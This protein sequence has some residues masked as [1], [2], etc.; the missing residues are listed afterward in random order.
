MDPS[1]LASLPEETRKVVEETFAQALLKHQ[2]DAG[3]TVREKQAQRDE[4]R[5][6]AGGGQPRS[7]AVP[8]PDQCS[9]GYARAQQHGWATGLS[10]GTFRISN[11]SRPKVFDVIFKSGDEVQQCW[12]LKDR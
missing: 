11:T 12:Y 5:A 7:S 3:A 1:I 2:Q 10:A 9:Q 8:S 4:E 6:H